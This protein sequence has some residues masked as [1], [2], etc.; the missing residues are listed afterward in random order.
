MNERRMTRVL[1]LIR[2]GAAVGALLL[3]G[4]CQRQ[5]APV[6]VD[7]DDIGGMVTSS[8]GAEA[9]VWV[10][11]ETTD[12]PTKFRKIV[13][14]DDRGRYLLPDLPKASYTVWV[15]GY[16]LV[17]SPAVVASPGT[18]VALA[19]VLA[20]DPRAAAAYY[21]ANYWLSLLKVPPKSAFPMTVPPPPPI[22][23][24][25]PPEKPT[26]GVAPDGRRLAEE[27]G[28][29]ED[30]P[31]PTVIQT[32]AEWLYDLKRGCETCHQ[33]GSTS[34]RT[35]PAS[36]GRFSSSTQAWER[37]L[38]SGQIGRGMISAL[39]RFGHA[40]GLALFADWSD[41]IAGG[42]VPPAPPRPQGIERNVV[43]TMWDFSVPM[44][45]LHAVISTDKRNPSV[46][47]NGLVYGTDWSAGALAV[48]NPA[49]NEKSLIKVPLP[50][51]KDRARLVP[52]SPQS[53]LASSVFWGDQLVWNDPVNPG[54]VTM[55]GQ[56]R[57][58]FIAETRIGNPAY[59]QS[60]SKNPFAMN[61][62]RDAG[63]KGVHVYD[64][65][66]HQFGAVDLCFRLER[67]VFAD[68]KDQTLYISV[69]GDG[70]I[71]WV[72]TRV[73]DETHDAEKAQGWCPAVLDDKIGAYTKANEPAEPGLDRAVSAPGA[74][75]VAS[76]PAD[77]SIWYSVIS[78]IPGKLVRM[79]PGAHAPA[80]CLTEVYEPPFDNPK[81]PG[82]RGYFPEGIDVDTN[83]VVW[84]PLTGDGDYASFD[85]RKCKGPLNGPTATGQHCPEG[86]T[87]YPV[88]GP[89]FKTEPQVKTDYNY[90]NWVDRFNALGLGKNAS[91]VDGANSDSLLV[92]QPD[93]RQWIRMHVPYPMGFFSRFLDARIDD[94]AAG[95]KGRGVWAANETRGSALTEGGKDM[96][97][98]LAHFQI[99]PDPLA[100]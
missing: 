68:D 78:P 10:I 18:T 6:A 46:N 37:M 84:T 79:I 8:H 32:Q 74:Y 61:S 80:T 7:A 53:Q 1:G 99:R 91:I 41:R 96:P 93:T 54:P 23:G 39:N 29:R 85:R 95:W 38:S 66:S 77:G 64:P 59:C 28:A 67:I 27:S 94:A 65:R 90:Y 83:G 21:P 73:W 81:A 55:D 11:A 52:W 75:S 4:A 88:P 30:R 48:V 44:S 47:A 12:L 13:V 9:G 70:G 60:G 17:D 97:S 98:Q 56:G 69:Q 42:E 16:G 82:V 33:M 50:D 49:T 57:V 100:K 36:L 5:A 45:F 87:I 62:P 76:N 34:T 22:G 20:P 89:T 3:V 71:G 14:T 26:H 58:W 19:A 24:V 86:W 40:E 35:I 43:V 15:R 51:E 2:V 63:G 72:N 92:F 31:V 25:A